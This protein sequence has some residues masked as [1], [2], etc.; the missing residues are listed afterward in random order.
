MNSGR[1]REEN[2]RRAGELVSRAAGG[3][4]EIIALPENFAFMRGS[5]KDRPA[6]EDLEGAIISWARETA[7]REGVYLLAG[8]FP[9]RSAI[10]DKVYNTSVLLGPEGEIIATYRKIHLFDV[11]IPGGEIHRE[12]ARVLPGQEAVVAEA[13]PARMGLTIC[14]DLRFG[15][16]YRRLADLGALIIFSP[17]AFTKQTGEAHWEV[18]IRARAIENQVFMI[19][20]AQQGTHPD[21]R[22]TYGHS[23]IVDPWGTVL[24]LIPEGEDVAVASLDLKK[25]AEI[26]KAMPCREHQARIGEILI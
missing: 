25:Q 19:A 1:D 26:R 13:T 3:G 2:L 4:A 8:S 18:L 21:G 12:S 22:R 6:G 9:E 11:S 15:A 7:C 23:M 16:L 17:A 14:Y 10:P 5:D 20:P 24:A